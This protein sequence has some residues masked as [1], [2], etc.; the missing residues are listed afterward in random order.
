MGRNAG[1]PSCLCSVQNNWFF[2]FRVFELDL[3]AAVVRSTTFSLMHEYHKLQHPAKRPNSKERN[4][5]KFIE[6]TT[7]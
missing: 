7:P 3:E 2:K 6:Q 5:L 4:E 1:N